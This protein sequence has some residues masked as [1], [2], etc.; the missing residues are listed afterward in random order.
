MVHVGLHHMLQVPSGGE[1][2]WWS[3]IFTGFNC[4][5]VPPASHCSLY[6]QSS[7]AFGVPPSLDAHTKPTYLVR[8]PPCHW[9][10]L[11]GRMSL[12]ILYFSQYLLI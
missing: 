1:A 7:N 3:L 10:S 8:N 2:S 11:T 4:I 12:E 9:L 6:A 5:I